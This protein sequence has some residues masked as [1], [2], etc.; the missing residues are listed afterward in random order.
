MRT[1]LCSLALGVLYVCSHAVSYSVAADSAGVITHLFT[2]W[3]RV[4]A[5]TVVFKVDRTRVETE[6]LHILEQVKDYYKIQ[7]V[8]GDSSPERVNVPVGVKL[9][10]EIAQKSKPW[11]LSEKPWESGSV[12][13]GTVIQ[14]GSRYRLW[15]SCGTAGNDKVVVAP[16]GRPK[17]GSEGGSAAMCY[18]E[19]EDGL[20]WKRPSLGLVEFQGSKDNNIL[21]ADRFLMA[22]VGS[23]F[24]DPAA[25]A[26]ERYKMVVPADIREFDPKAQGRA[27][28]LGG[29]VSSDGMSWRKLP[30]PLW[31]ESFNN[32]GTPVVYRDTQTGKYGLF[33]RGNSPRRRSIS[34]AVTDDFRRWPHPEII[35]TPGP[36][37]DPSDDFYTNAYLQYPGAANGHLMLVSTYHRDTS[38]V[39]LRLASSMDGSGWNWLSPHTVVKLGKAGDWDGGSMY[40]V[41]NMVRLADGRVAVPVQGYSSAHEEYWR[42]KFE[43]GRARKEAVGWA[44]WEDGRIAGIEAEEAGEFTTLPFAFQ[45]KDIEINCRT[46]YSGSVRVELIA[47]ETVIRSRQIVGDHLWARVSW[48]GNPNVASLGGRTIRL[49]FQLYNAKVFGFRGEGMTVVSP[50]R[51]K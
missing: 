8:E 43:R 42:V 30:G 6:S 32:D 38:L 19:S 44:I 39:D 13:A 34:R 29:A 50:Y 3:Y 36:D 33:T 14:D 21:T 35:L 16:N 45:G 15:Y 41:P 46:G 17:L 4:D 28:V 10:A 1:A 25:P 24:L 47:D 5:G 49:R 2:N 7:L 12:G 27:G 22:G 23:I 26:E 48:E 37:E 31:R 40:A 9:R 20:H 18:Q 51:M 11:L